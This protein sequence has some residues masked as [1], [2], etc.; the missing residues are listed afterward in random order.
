M[1][2]YTAR[3]NLYAPKLSEKPPNRFILHIVIYDPA[4]GIMQDYTAR[5]Y[6]T[7]SFFTLF[8]R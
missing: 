5:A 7:L 4:K 1:Q 2:D 8:T 3:A 6:L